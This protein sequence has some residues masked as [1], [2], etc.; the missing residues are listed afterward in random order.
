MDGAMCKKACEALNIPIKV[1]TNNPLYR[2][3]EDAKGFCYQDGL[4]GP[5]VGFSPG[6]SLVCLDW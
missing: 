4:D 3:Y 5:S 6:A 2:C 1:I